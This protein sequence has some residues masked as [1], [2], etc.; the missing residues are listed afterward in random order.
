M[1][2][3]LNPTVSHNTPL[4]IHTPNPPST[5]YLYCAKK[6]EMVVASTFLTVCKNSLQYTESPK[7]KTKSPKSEREKYSSER[8]ETGSDT[9]HDLL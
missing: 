5:N 6:R 9:S 3:I 4:A 8:E 7:T 1:E 2:Y